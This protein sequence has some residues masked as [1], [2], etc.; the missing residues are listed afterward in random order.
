MAAGTA[1]YSLTS[2]EWSTLGSAP[3]I[4]QVQSGAVIVAVSPAEP[5]AS[6]PGIGLSLGS[7]PLQVTGAGSLWAK[8]VTASARV[9]VATL[10]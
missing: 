8:A 7:E 10:A 2:T 1:A 4:L 3:A 5:G 9:V 6:D